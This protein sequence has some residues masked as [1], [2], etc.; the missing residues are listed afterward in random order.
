MPTIQI[1]VLAHNEEQ[2]IGACLASL[3]AGAQDIVIAAI[4][5]GSTDHTARIVRQFPEVTLYEYP[6]GGKSRSW[7]RFMLDTPGILADYYIFVDGDSEL[8]PGSIEALVRTLDENPQANA[9]S[10][11]PLNG[12]KAQ[13]YRK[14]IAHTHGLFG[15]LYAL[16]GDF[17]DRMRAKN[18]RL[19]EDLVG[20][21]GLI[22]ALAKTDLQDESQWQ[23]DRVVPCEKAG[24][25]CEPVR[26]SRS[27]LTMQYRRMVNYSLR[28]FQ[29]RIVTDIMRSTGPAGL[30][31]RLAPL[32]PNYL[33][34]FRPRVHPEWWW[35]DR[36]ALRRMADAA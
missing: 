4:V 28:H 24:F 17:V 18:I 29:N 16:R 34:R 26:I 5:N 8:A 35:F 14:A 9:A 20:D 31:L 2:R 10:G 1:V 13:A 7:N 11:L 6:Q 33:L 32:Y 22:G 36:Q 19:P 27:S 3:P 23:D 25:Y 15:D 21:D 30:P 12:R